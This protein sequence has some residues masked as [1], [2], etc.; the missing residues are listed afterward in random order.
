MLITQQ[1]SV[2]WHAHQVQHHHAVPA[3]SITGRTIVS[4]FRALYVVSG[5]IILIR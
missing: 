2:L 5:K 3:S 4:V 1:T